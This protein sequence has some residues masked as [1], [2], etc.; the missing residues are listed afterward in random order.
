MPA[1]ATAPPVVGM[2]FVLMM[3]LTAT[4]MPCNG[5]DAARSDAVE[6]S[7][8]PACGAFAIERVGLVQSRAAQVCH[9]IDAPVIAIDPVEVELNE[10]PRSDPSGIECQLQLGDA[11]F[12][13]VEA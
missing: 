9:R 4:G 8:E 13:D 12:D 3:S 2:S 7:A 6:W 1:N 5:P 11:R 10:L